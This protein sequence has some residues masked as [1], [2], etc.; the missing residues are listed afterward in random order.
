[1]RRAARRTGIGIGI[2]ICFAIGC[3]SNLFPILPPVDASAD[4]DAS[5][6]DASAVCQMPQPSDAGAACNTF[7]LTGSVVQ[8]EDLPDGGAGATPV[9]GTLVDGDYD[10]VRYQVPG[11]GSTRRTIRLFGGGTRIEW[12]VADPTASTTIE[13]RANTSITPAGNTLQVTV[14]CMANGL[15]GTTSYGYTASGDELV[16]FYPY[17]STNPLVD[18]YTYRRTCTRAP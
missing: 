2:A 18:V 7:E 6:A 8:A 14:D 17:P 12:A 1:M 4:T 15:F 13:L 9:G 5:P 16:I 10:L 3:S 11:T